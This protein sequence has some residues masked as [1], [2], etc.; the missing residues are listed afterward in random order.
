MGAPTATRDGYAPEWRTLLEHLAATAADEPRCSRCHDAHD[1]RPYYLD[2]LATLC[3][4]CYRSLA[5]PATIAAPVD[6]A[7]LSD[8]AVSEIVALSAELRHVQ[9]ERLCAAATHRRL[10][11]AVL[12][13]LLPLTEDA[14]RRIVRA[15]PATLGLNPN[16]SV[17]SVA[18]TRALALHAADAAP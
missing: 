14:V 6:V 17:Y 11:V 4:P 13:E 18:A 12:A 16:Q 2:G 15:H 7:Q 8:A 1:D 3:G 10:P 5:D 9:I